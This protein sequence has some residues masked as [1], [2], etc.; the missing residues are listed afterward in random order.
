VAQLADGGDIDEYVAC[1]AEDAV[2]EMPANPAVGLTA[3]T[4]DG[5]AAIRAGA[6]DR[7]AAGVQGPGT[8]TRH[9][10]GTT[11]VDV[12]DDQATAQSY[13]V[14]YADTTGAMRPQTMGEYFDAFTCGPSGWRLRYRRIVLG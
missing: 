6:V 12:R 10:V 3:A 7:R 11:S 8:H 5:A 14:F 9:H 4:L 13:F 2:W 1:Y